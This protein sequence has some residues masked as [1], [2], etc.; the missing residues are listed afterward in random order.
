MAKATKKAKAIGAPMARVSMPAGWMNADSDALFK[1]ILDL[2]N[3]DEARAFF[4]D[5]LTEKEII[6]FSNRWKA[7]NM[8]ARG[9]SYF[10]IADATGMSS[11]TIARINNWLERGMGGY[12]A[13]IHHSH[14][15]TP[16]SGGKGLR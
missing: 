3:L 7:A 13:A 15:H 12:K 6:E 10:D 1:A 8:L 9:K 14:P 5:L 4:R 2:S 11:T 16:A